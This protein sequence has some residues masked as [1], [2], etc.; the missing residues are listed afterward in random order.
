MLRW[1]G[2]SGLGILML[3]VAVPTVVAAVLILLPPLYGG[4][5]WQVRLVLNEWSLLLVLPAVLSLLLAAAARWSGS[6]LLS[7]LI[8][9]LAVIALGL[10]LL[11]PIRGVAAANHAGV[12]LDPF[13]YFAG[14]V[15]DSVR[16]PDDTATYDR[17]TGL[18]LDIWRPAG[19]PDQ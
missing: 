2:R 12:R 14:T 10:A 6:R 15:R 11:P 9:A 3:C 16:R 17:V 13:E 8:G 1:L 19:Q 18:K 4:S 7:G 5:G